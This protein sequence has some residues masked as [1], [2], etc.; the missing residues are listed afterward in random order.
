M[1]NEGFIQKTKLPCDG[2]AMVLFRRWLPLEG[3]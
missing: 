2:A 3:M 1:S